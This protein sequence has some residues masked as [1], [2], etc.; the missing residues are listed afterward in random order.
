MQVFLGTDRNRK[1]KNFL[2]PSKCELTSVKYTRFAEGKCNI[3]Y[4]NC[5]CI[6]L[7]K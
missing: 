3:V 5:R 7:R 2:R 4:D 6:R 1:H